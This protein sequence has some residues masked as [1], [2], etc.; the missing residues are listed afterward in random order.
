MNL[1]VAADKNWAIGNKGRLLVTI[2]EDQKLF[3]QETLG[4]VIV[5]GRKT[6]ESLPGGRPFR[7]VPMWSSQGTGIIKK[8]E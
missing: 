2:P 1:I 5:M 6:M 4:K 3:R 8:R 7:D